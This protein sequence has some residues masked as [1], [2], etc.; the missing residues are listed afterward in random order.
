VTFLSCSIEWRDNDG[1]DG[2]DGDNFTRQ[3]LHF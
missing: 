2:G 1:D 3:A